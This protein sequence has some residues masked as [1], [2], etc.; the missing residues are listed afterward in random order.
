[1]AAHKVGNLIRT[2]T[3][4]RAATTRAEI[5]VMGEATAALREVTAHKVADTAPR[6]VTITAARAAMVAAP[7]AVD[8]MVLKVAA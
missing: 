4:H 7:R 1:V 3:V 8:R 2:I 5:P 6:V